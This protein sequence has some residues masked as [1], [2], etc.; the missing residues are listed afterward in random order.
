LLA[1]L[2]QLELKWRNG[3][4]NQDRYNS[5]RRKLMADLEQIYAELDDTETA[6]PGGG[7]EGVAA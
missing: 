5:R 7:G 1:D 2:E 3:A 6:G 4:V